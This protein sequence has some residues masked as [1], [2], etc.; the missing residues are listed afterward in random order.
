LSIIHVLNL[1]PQAA[2]LK[3]LIPNL[4]TGSTLRDGALFLQLSSQTKQIPAESLSKDPR[5]LA[6]I[7]NA[8]AR[9]G[10]WDEELFR[11]TSR[12]ARITD[13]ST[14]SVNDCAAL[15]GSFAKAQTRQGARLRD[16]ALFRRMSLTVQ[17]KKPESFT[18]RAATNI[19]S[20]F[21]RAGVWD[22]LLFA[23]ITRIALNL[24]GVNSSQ[25]LSAFKNQVWV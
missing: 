10:V 11:H 19:L 15:V 18:A 4:R 25:P 8:F 5:A 17:A 12:A 1:E 16:G 9:A 24:Q 20:S 6:N 2:N 22:L 13:P 23:R 21:A 14:I 3:P 7:V